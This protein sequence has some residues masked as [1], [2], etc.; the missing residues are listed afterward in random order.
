V[1]ELDDAAVELALLAADLGQPRR[2]D[3]VGEVAE[4]AS[5]ADG[6]D[7]ARVADQHQL[8][9][10]GLGELGQLRRVEGRRRRGFV[11]HDH[12]AAGE[13]LRLQQ[14]PTR[15][16]G[17]GRRRSRSRGRRRRRSSAEA[18]RAVATPTTG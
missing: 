13:R 3:Q 14:P 4:E 16:R 8:A 7:L 12:G 11:D 9:A 1:G 5:G 6:A 15:R 2:L 17:G 10:A 18:V